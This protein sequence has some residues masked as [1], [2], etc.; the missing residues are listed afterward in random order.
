MRKK[1]YDT[2]G[3]QKRILRQLKFNPQAFLHMLFY[4]ILILFS[5]V[6]FSFY[7]L[8]FFMVALQVYLKYLIV[9]IWILFTPQL[10]A[11]MVGLSMVMSNGFEF[12]HLNS[13]YKSLLKEDKKL[14]LIYRVIPF[15]GL[16]AW[17]STLFLFMYVAFI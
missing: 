8:S 10:L 12:G 5:L 17:I 13:S 3:S 1:T 7:A 15:I 14:G 6:A 4:R 2:R 9:I 16:L 11:L